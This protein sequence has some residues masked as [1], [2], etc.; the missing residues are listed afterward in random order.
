[1]NNF[2]VLLVL[3]I[4]A[5]I[6]L[7]AQGTVVF[8]NSRANPLLDSS[9]KKL[10]GTNY[11]AQLYAGFPPALLFP[12]SRIATFHTGLFA[13]VMDRADIVVIPWRGEGEDLWFQVR[14]WEAIGGASFESAAAGGYWTGV[15]QFLYVPH[16]GYTCDNPCFPPY[17]DK[18]VYPGLPLVI[19]QSKN[20]SI[21]AGSSATVRLLATGT[22][23]MSQQWYE[24]LSGD[25]NRPIAG[26]T[27]LILNTA[28]I[29]TST[30]FWCRLTT[31][32]G[33]TDSESSRVT[34]YPADA[35]FLVMQ[36]RDQLPSLW[37]DGLTNVP[38]RLEY[39]TN[40]GAPN[41]LP[42]TEFT[43]P[44]SPFVF[45]DPAIS[46]SPLRYYRILPR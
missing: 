9:G 38:Y 33:R 35:P 2:F 4:F 34:V 3:L 25:T 19:E 10:S 7:L 24:G 28:P 31:A 30:S 41:W 22:F 11:F 6:K 16:L 29:V 36:Q 27:N 14:T 43:L 26:A 37:I 15:S 23:A 46:N 32:V 12:V 21:R 20:Q 17:L 5:D 18:L 40:L 39:S 44:S 42:L 1:M 45:N 8:Q 13:G